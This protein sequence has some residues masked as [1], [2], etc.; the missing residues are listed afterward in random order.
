MKD[1]GRKRFKIDK[2]GIS[3]PIDIQ[4]PAGAAELLQMI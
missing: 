4:A 2:W 1:E 3:V